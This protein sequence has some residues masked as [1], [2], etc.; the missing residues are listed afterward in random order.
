MPTIEIEGF[1]ACEAAA[2]TRLVRAIEAC[3]VDVSHRCGGHARCTTCRVEFLAGEPQRIT[4][5]EVA[6]LREKG[7]LGSVRLS[8]QC[9]VEGDLRLKVLMPVSAQPWDEPGPPPEEGIT[10]EPEWLDRADLP[11]ADPG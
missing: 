3:G 4:R 1:G 8:C 2:G 10:P 5:A 6:K 9:L 11:T 7:L